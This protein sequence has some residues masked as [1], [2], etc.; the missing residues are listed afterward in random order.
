MTRV[1]DYNY[2]FGSFMGVFGLVTSLGAGIQMMHICYY[3]DARGVSPAVWVFSVVCNMFWVLY[4]MMILD[5]V[6]LI[7][8]VGSIFSSAS[9]LVAIWYYKPARDTKPADIRLDKGA[10]YT[11]SNKGKGKFSVLED[12]TDVNVSF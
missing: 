11:Q 5:W 4:S 2:E 7:N 9:V 12:E 1:L 10:K 8:S 3:H 6:V